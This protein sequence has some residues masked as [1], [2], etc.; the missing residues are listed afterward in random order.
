MADLTTG[1]ELVHLLHVAACPSTLTRGWDDRVVTA[2]AL[3]PPT[4]FSHRRS[5][6]LISVP[7]W[8]LV[9]YGHRVSCLNFA[10]G[11]TRH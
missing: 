7:R 5:R 4:V 3:T 8:L 11:R 10:A 9:R 2:E 1:A 6:P